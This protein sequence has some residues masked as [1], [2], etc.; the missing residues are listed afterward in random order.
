MRSTWVLLGVVGAGLIAVGTGPVR[1]QE[2]VAA[3]AGAARDTRVAAVV[4]SLP[5]TPAPP[6]ATETAAAH[7]A[8][9]PA[10][11]KS[12]AAPTAHSDTL[13]IVLGGDL[14]LGGS[15]Q[16]VHAEGAL[17]HGA[18]QNWADLTRG[19]APLLDG[20]I[21]FANLETVV[22]D[23]NDL[24][25]V[26]KAFNFRSHPAGI[27]HLVAA[28][29]N[30]VSTANNHAIDYGEPGIRETLR[31]LRGLSD[32]GLKGLPGIG[33][34]R[35]EA[36]AP[37]DVIVRNARVRIAALGIGGGALP[38][39]AASAARA[40]MASYNVPVDVS[41]SVDGLAA[42]AGDIRILSVHY[43]QEL[44]VRPSAVDERRL[45]EV[46]A[47]GGIDIVA[48]HHAH[49]AAGVQ[50]TD[51]RMIFYGLGNLL[52]P[53]MQ[54][55]DRLGICRDYGLVAR[56]HMIR[57]GGEKFRI[58][59]VEIITLRGMH[60]A[61]QPRDGEAGRLR[62]EV[63]NHLAAGLDDRTSGARGVRF[64]P[65]PDGSGLYCAAAVGARIGD[66]QDRIGR[67][68]QTF[69]PPEAPAPAITRRITQACGGIDL[70]ARRQGA[71]ELAADGSPAAR[72][73]VTRAGGAAKGGGDSFLASIF[74]P[75]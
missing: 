40:G 2:A 70:I 19:I 66:G 33:I 39:G 55:M 50:E 16:P 75:W 65:Q 28:G 45:R 71:T 21:N 47:A 63:I 6:N 56:V 7:P 34:G 53:G 44:Q 36:L 51:G 42:A 35:A 22:T 26:A 68:C 14:G 15:E 73:R 48:G 5:L 23:R 12:P 41:D 1:A 64:A 10:A 30:V 31:H 59:A 18:R 20:D 43:G 58:R 8:E 29:F 49:V 9:P 38:A 24:S 54:D 13:T 17:R 32:A 37:A 67:L 60:Q 69:T 74:K 46:A 72:R 52:H 27:R 25:P 3:T 4:G 11:E 62:V 61:P 57:T